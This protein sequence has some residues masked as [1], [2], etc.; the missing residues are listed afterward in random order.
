[1]IS[2]SCE[3]IADFLRLFHLYSCGTLINF[4]TARDFATVGRSGNFLRS[5]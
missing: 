1:M 4:S 3:K 2:L 5:T